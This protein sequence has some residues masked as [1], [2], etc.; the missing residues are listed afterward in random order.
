MTSLPHKT[1]SKTHNALH[2]FQQIQFCSNFI[3][4]MR[5]HAILERKLG[6][7][8]G[9]LGSF[10]G[11]IAYELYKIMQVLTSLSLSSLSTKSVTYIN[12]FQLLEAVLLSKSLMIRFTFKF[13]IVF[14]TYHD[15]KSF[16]NPV[17]GSQICITDKNSDSNGKELNTAL[18]NIIYSVMAIHTDVYRD[19]ISMS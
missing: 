19:N 5:H 9:N 6:Q 1:W 16:I 4:V 3:C 8:S 2:A 10:S 17:F 14:I 7:E 18:K 13:H 11:C 15:I 12:I